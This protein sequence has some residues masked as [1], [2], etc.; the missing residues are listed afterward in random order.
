M[1]NHQFLY[2]FQCLFI[3]FEGV[4]AV[5]SNH[6][7]AALAVSNVLVSV[8]LII[9]NVILDVS[10]NEGAWVVCANRQY[11]FPLLRIFPF[12]LTSKSLNTT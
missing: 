10:I 5:Q 4:R 8:H 9:F 6:F 12:R 7:I 2:K 3:V 11:V 1:I